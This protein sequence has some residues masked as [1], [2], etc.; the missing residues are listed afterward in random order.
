M[1][2]KPYPSEVFVEL[3][4]LLKLQALARGFSFQAGRQRV[5]SIMS[6]KHASKLRGRGLDF[7]EVRKYVP[8]D[9][10]RNI[11][12]KVTARTRKTHARVYSEE[13]EKPALIVVDQTRSMF[14]GSIRKTKST[15]AAELAA[16]AAFRVV[17]EGDR[18]GGIVFGDEK[19]EMLMPKRDRKNVLRFLE[20]LCLANQALQSESQ[21]DFEQTLSEVMRRIA[22]V[23]THDYLI[24]VIS[25]FHRYDPRVVRNLIKLARNN[26]LILAKVYD[27]FESQ[28]PEQAIIAGDNERQLTIDGR[29]P[30]NRQKFNF[31]FDDRFQRFKSDMQQH[32]IPV[33]LFETVTDID[34]QLKNAMQKI[35]P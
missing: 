29:K 13:K 35:A 21:T 1:T 19:T 23:V 4:D 7:E 15:V 31:D 14:F 9:D 25:D 28:L 24:F 26:D 6:G 2:D 33:L 20:H 30:E 32:G 22:N 27:P 3:Q 12:W 5:R 16:L 10:I 11:D 8:G 18:V 17:K 34:S